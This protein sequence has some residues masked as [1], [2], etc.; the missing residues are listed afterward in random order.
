M[1][2]QKAFVTVEVVTPA[3]EASGGFF[4][5]NNVPSQFLLNDRSPCSL[6]GLNDSD[7][8]LFIRLC[9]RYRDIPS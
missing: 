5:I 7:L 6:R 1:Q 3:P 8:F 4:Y 9:N 2:Q